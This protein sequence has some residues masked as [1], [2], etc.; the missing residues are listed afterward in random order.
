MT[1]KY[2]EENS[3]AV[4]D[5]YQLLCDSDSSWGTLSSGEK[6]VICDNKEMK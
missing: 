6:W 4:A 5:R 3:V 1:N 2:V